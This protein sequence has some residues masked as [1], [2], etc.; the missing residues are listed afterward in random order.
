M[1]Y[2]EDIN[3]SWDDGRKSSAKR[4]IQSRE[5]K[6][7]LDLAFPR[8]GE[9]LLDVGCGTGEHLLFF[10]NQGCSVTGVEAS[11]ARIE[12][13]KKRLGHRADIHAGR[14]EELPFSDNEFDVVTLIA[15]LEFAEDPKKAIS[16]AIRVSRNRV[17]MGTWNKY[18]IMNPRGAVKDISNSQSGE[19]PVNLLGGLQLVHWIRNM[20]PSI[21]IEWGS[22]IF[23]PVDWYTY[24]AGIE[25]RMPI[26]KN[27]FGA[28]LGFSFPVRTSYR[29]IQD[30]IAVP[31]GVHSKTRQPLQG[32]AI[33]MKGEGNHC[34]S[35]SL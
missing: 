16:E 27:P 18:A 3:P 28:F 4:F 26:R 34:R 6:L 12:A 31:R 11:F 23:F 2:H 33:G 7:I 14:A 13:A 10:R 21:P 29:T 20:L 8:A 15:S 35:S 5:E 22:V 32:V 25:Q 30:V 9:R 17:F 19:N 1:L 24:L